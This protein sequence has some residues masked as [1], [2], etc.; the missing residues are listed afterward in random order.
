MEVSIY[1]GLD[2]LILDFGKEWNSWVHEILTFENIYRYSCNLSWIKLILF[3]G[4]ISVSVCHDGM[5]K[6]LFVYSKIFDDSDV[7]VTMVTNCPLLRHFFYPLHPIYA[8]HELFG[9]DCILD[10]IHVSSIGEI[11]VYKNSMY[12]VLSWLFCLFRNIWFIFHLGTC[13]VS[14]SYYLNDPQ[15][16]KLCTNCSLV[17]FL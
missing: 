5:Y 9:Q 2:S 11:S 17:E 8:S 3:L 14:I 6:V 1:N 12:I 15:L 7:L 10:I 16:H 13:T 4:K